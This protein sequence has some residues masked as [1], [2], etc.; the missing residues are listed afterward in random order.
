MQ[1]LPDTHRSSDTQHSL[2]H[3]YFVLS[4]TAECN[5][6]VEGDAASCDRNQTTQYCAT[7][8]HA[9][10]TTHCASAVG[11]YR[12]QSGNVLDVFLRGCSDCTGTRSGISSTYHLV[13]TFKFYAPFLSATLNLSGKGRGLV[14][15]GESGVKAKIVA[16]YN[17]LWTESTS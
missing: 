8:E 1:T 2:I 10:G 4:L 6:C 7:S 9:L 14:F 3:N 11:K 15:S 13:V 5:A 12:D 17:K 16:V